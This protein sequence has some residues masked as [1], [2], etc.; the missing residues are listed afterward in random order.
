MY[1]TVTVC[2][3]GW[4]RITGT[5]SVA[6]PERGAVCVPTPGCTVGTAAPVSSARTAANAGF[7]APWYVNMP[8]F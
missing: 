6:V 2:E 3:L 8:M 1:A 7:A 5:R 4:S